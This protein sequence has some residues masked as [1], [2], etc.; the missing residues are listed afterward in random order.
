[1]LPEY[2]RRHDLSRKDIDTIISYIPTKVIWMSALMY[3]IY[4]PWYTLRSSAASVLDVT[5]SGKAVAVDLL[6]EK[7]GVRPSDRNKLDVESIESFE[8]IPPIPK[9]T[10]SPEDFRFISSGVVCQLLPRNLLLPGESI[11]VVPLVYMYNGMC[12]VPVGIEG[13]SICCNVIVPESTYTKHRDTQRQ[14]FTHAPKVCSYEDV[15]YCL[16]DELILLCV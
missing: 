8:H 11:G 4:C 10:I 7:A 13:D 9:S 12:V 2:W 5:L 16:T 14:S 15:I 1:V 6:L 3:G